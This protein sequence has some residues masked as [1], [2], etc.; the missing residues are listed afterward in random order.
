MSNI[1]QLR[2]PKPPRRSTLQRD[3]LAWLMLLA[4]AAASFLSVFLPPLRGLETLVGLAVMV[5][6]YAA[7]YDRA[8]G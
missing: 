6:G 1:H 5:G 3:T 7:L 4:G 8:R 2:R